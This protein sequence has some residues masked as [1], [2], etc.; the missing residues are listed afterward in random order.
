MRINHHE[1]DRQF[2]FNSGNVPYKAT[3]NRNIPFTVLRHHLLFKKI[4]IKAV[5]YY[6][7]IPTEG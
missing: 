1:T 3:Y 2:Q 5:P 7:Y 6:E 4:A